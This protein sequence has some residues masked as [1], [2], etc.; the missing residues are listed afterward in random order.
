MILL[1]LNCHTFDFRILCLQLTANAHHRAA[2]ANTH[3]NVC[4]FFL[5]VEVRYID[6]KLLLKIHWNTNKQIDP[7][8]YLV[9]PIVF[10]DLDELNM[11]KLTMS[12]SYCDLVMYAFY[13][14]GGIQGF[15]INIDYNKVKNGDIYV[16]AGKKARSR[17]EMFSDMYDIETCSVKELPK[18]VKVY[19]P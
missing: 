18:K 12:D 4:Y 5:D 3:N 13:K 17:A 2:C 11:K 16:F 9:R 14:K 6:Q 7:K 10:L 1:R 8:Q 15:D 19:S